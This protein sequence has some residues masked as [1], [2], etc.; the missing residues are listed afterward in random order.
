[1]KERRKKDSK[2]VKNEK[3]MIRAAAFN[4]GFVTGYELAKKEGAKACGSSLNG[5][6][7]R[8]GIV[9]HP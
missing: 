2:K 9:I 5:L 7:G 6:Q 1:M 3:E 4:E 8:E